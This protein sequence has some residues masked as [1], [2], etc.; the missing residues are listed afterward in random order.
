MCDCILIIRSTPHLTRCLRHGAVIASL[1]CQIPIKPLHTIPTVAQQKKAITATTLIKALGKPTRTS[2]QA[3]RLDALGI[4]FKDLF[5]LYLEISN[6]EA[7]HT[8]LKE[9]GI[10]SKPLR[11]KLEK[12]LEQSRRTST[13]HTVSCT[14]AVSYSCRTLLR[15]S[16]QITKDFTDTIVH[17][18]LYRGRKGG[19]DNW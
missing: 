5:N 2:T 3:K 15:R 1:T 14:P 8:V 10:N 18:L 13:Q 6:R 4:E 9:R 11:E 19:A 7:F 17:V 16:H 12:T